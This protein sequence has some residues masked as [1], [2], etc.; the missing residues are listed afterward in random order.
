MSSS[1]WRTQRG[2]GLVLASES[3][4]GLPYGGTNHACQGQHMSA[5]HT[6]ARTRPLHGAMATSVRCM[7]LQERTGRARGRA[8]ANH[9]PRPAERRTGS[10]LEVGPSSSTGRRDCLCRRARPRA[11]LVRGQPCVQRRPSAGP[12]SAARSC[13]VSA[14]PRRAPW[15]ATA[16]R[17]FPCCYAAFARSSLLLLLLLLACFCS[18]LPSLAPPCLHLPLLDAVSRSSCS[19]FRGEFASTTITCRAN[20]TRAGS[21]CPVIT[22]AMRVPPP[23]PGQ[24]QALLGRRRPTLERPGWRSALMCAGILVLT[25]IAVAFMFVVVSA[26]ACVPLCCAR[27]TPAPAPHLCS[28]STSL[29]LAACA[30]VGQGGRLVDPSACLCR[31]RRCAGSRTAP[32][33]REANGRARRAGARVSHVPSHCL[34]PSLSAVCWHSPLLARTNVVVVLLGFLSPDGVHGASGPRAL[35]SWP[36]GGATPQRGRK[37]C[38]CVCVCARACMDACLR[39]PRPRPRAHTHAHTTRTRTHMHTHTHAHAHTDSAHMRHALADEDANA[40]ARAHTHTRTRRETRRA[41]V[42]RGGYSGAERQG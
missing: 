30:L 19:R 8:R 3:R 23:N 36:Q 40:C 22:S 15:T 17:P 4:T 1:C 39:A 42:K 14:G 29:R 41:V 9:G 27:K 37:G 5:V 16:S 32:S 11:G 26:R 10:H 18:S 35:A 7:L 20:W 2:C 21:C 25:I 6:R 34:V 38:V 33:R 13:R 12:S 24:G 31:A 28:L